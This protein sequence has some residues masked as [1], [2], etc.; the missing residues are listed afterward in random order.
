MAFCYWAR[1][2]VLFAPSLFIL[3]KIL[4]GSHRCTVIG[5]P[6]IQDNYFTACQ[7]NCYY[8]ILYSCLKML[9]L[10]LKSFRLYT[11]CCILK[12]YKLFH[13]GC[14]WM[15]HYIVTN[16]ENTH[17]FKLSKYSDINNLVYCLP[18]IIFYYWK[19]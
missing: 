6:Q 19:I 5:L 1:R 12:E 2:L 10:F 14:L 9:K 8:K 4:M 15:L 3:T 13:T 17:Y 7:I 11:M 18:F 16:V